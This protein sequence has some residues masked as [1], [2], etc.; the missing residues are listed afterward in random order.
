MKEYINE[1]EFCQYRYESYYEY[2]TG[3][4]EYECELTRTDCTE[5]C[6]LNFKFEYEE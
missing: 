2:D 5:D 4:C 6:P 1:C 3:Y